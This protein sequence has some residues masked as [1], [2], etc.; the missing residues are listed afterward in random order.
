M[1]TEQQRRMTLS[2]DRLLDVIRVQTEIVQLGIDLDKV[3]SLVVEKSQALTG[4]QGG[5]IELA[6]GDEMVYRA[7]SGLA[8]SQLGLRL[9]RATSLSGA[10]ISTGTPLS[11]RD[12]E[13][14]PRVDRDACRRVGLR[15]MIVVPLKQEEAV[16]GVLKVMSDKP[17]AFDEEHIEVLELMSGLIAAS[18]ANATRYELGE[19][20]H[21]ATHDA[22][23]E[24]CNRSVFYDH[25]RQRLAQ[26]RRSVERFGVLMLDMDG[27]KKIN[28]ELGHRAGDAAIKEFASRIKIASR[29]SDTVARLGGDEFGIILYQVTH[30]EETAT[31]IRRL[32]QQVSEP[33]EFELK[34]LPLAVSIGAA[35][36]PDD[37]DDVNV[38][39]EKADQ[40][41]YEMKRSQKV[42]RQPEQQA[43]ISL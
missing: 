39:V 7:V 15:S 11:C 21:R 9:N 24:L 32:I 4:S 38:L 1:V 20:Y 41:M 35:V 5:V 29:E 40:F 18:M 42:M 33:F 36:F 30:P 34:P 10:C 25:L 23:T 26:S 2:P 8:K 14:D 37:G 3:M 17:E 22:L 19:I 31:A 43:A 6:E 12:S 16:I 28:D 27:L 13:S